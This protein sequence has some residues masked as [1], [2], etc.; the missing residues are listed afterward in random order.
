MIDSSHDLTAPAPVT[1]PITY[2][3]FKLLLRSD[4][5]TQ[6]AHFHQF[7]KLTRHAAKEVGIEIRK[8]GKPLE[9]RLREVLFFD[10]PEFSFYN[11][12]FILRRRM[13]Y[14]K[15]LPATNYELTLKFRHRDRVTAAAADVHP[16][17]P[18]KHTIKFKDE[19]LMDGAKI[20]TMRSIYSHGCELDTPDTI[21]TRSFDSIANVFPSLLATGATA[22]TVLKVVNEVAIE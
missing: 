5:F 16:R 15:G 3:E 8:R 1:D 21:L 11:H 4:C 2:R 14:K 12:G 22:E 7:W 9:T 10:T 13:F 6:P 19:I 18:C 20:G 17:L